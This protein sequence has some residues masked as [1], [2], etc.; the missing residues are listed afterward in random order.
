[1]SQKMGGGGGGSHSGSLD[2]LRWTS[3][4]ESSTS[5]SS[6]VV[7][8]IDCVSFTLYLI[9]RDFGMDR[10]Q[11]SIPDSLVHTR[12]EYPGSLAKF[13]WLIHWNRMVLTSGI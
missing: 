6:T 8:H 10:G 13:H 2:I 3:S 11:S 9:Q 4:G 5:L 1:M 7:S 12:K